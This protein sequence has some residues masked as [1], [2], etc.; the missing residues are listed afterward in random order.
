M[1]VGLVLGNQAGVK[2]LRDL[3]DKFVLGSQV[4]PLE[5]GRVLPVHKGYPSLVNPGSLI[6]YCFKGKTLK[7]LIQELP[8]VSM[9]NGNIQ[10]CPTKC[11]CHVLRAA[12]SSSQFKTEA[13]TRQSLKSIQCYL[14]VSNIK[15]TD[16]VIWLGLSCWVSFPAYSPS[17]LCFRVWKQSNTTRMQNFSED[18]LSP[19]SSLIPKIICLLTALEVS[20]KSSLSLGTNKILICV[21]IGWWQTQEKCYLVV[22]DQKVLSISH[23]PASPIK[24]PPWQSGVWV[25]L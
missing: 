13:S 25:C 24:S 22:F 20:Q 7:R 9:D 21:M 18:H 8:W 17:V 3:E 5:M 12:D 4:P 15:D 10:G 11:R 2:D 23:L 19:L 16:A 14:L 1:R 6:S